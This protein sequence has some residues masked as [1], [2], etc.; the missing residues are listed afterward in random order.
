MKKKKKKYYYKQEWKLS[1]FLRNASDSAFFPRHWVNSL[2]DGMKW[3]TH[4][5]FIFDKILV[6]SHGSLRFW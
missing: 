2:K 1:W 5:L 6:F 3:M 4:S